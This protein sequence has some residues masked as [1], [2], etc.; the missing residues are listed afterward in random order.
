MRQEISIA[1]KYYAE[2]YTAFGIDQRR[3]DDAILVNQF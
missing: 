3:K 1:S 2:S